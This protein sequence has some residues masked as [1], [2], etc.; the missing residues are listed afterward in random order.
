[1]SEDDVEERVIIGKVGGTYG[2]KGWMHIQSFT[3][4]I[5]NILAYDSLDFRLR[6]GWKTLNIANGKLHGKGIVLQVEGC[7]TPEAAKQYTH[8]E[9]A[10]FRDELPELGDNEYYWRDLQGMQVVAEDQT[11]LGVVEYMFAT[12]S[13]DVMV[14]KGEQ[15]HLIPFIP[16][17]I[18]N[19]DEEQ[20]IIT[21]RWD[22]DF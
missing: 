14:V 10:V 19:V 4:P 2:V 6:N 3:D 9:L 5:D 8:C 1:M 11:S 21:V 20:G 16:Q 13:N 18:V 17:S 22:P 15:E 12:G 7:A